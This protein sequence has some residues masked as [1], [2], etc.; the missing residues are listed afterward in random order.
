MGDIVPIA[1]GVRSNRSRY[2]HEG[3]ARLINCY[4]EVI[5]EEGKT[6]TPVYA[7]DGLKSW[8][9]TSAA[10]VRAMLALPTTLYAVV[11]RSIVAYDTTGNETVIG[12]IIGDGL[13]TMARNR[14]ASTQ[15]GICA[16]GIFKIAVGNAVVSVTDADLPPANS[17]THFDGYF[18]LTI[19]DGRF[20]VTAL[21]DGTSIDGL[22][23]AKAEANPDGLVR[24]AVRNRDLVLFGTKSTEFWSNTGGED[25][26]FTRTTSVDRGC[27]AP[28]SVADLDQTLAFVADDGTVRRLD[29]YNATRIST[30]DLER[31][32]DKDPN[33]EDI[34]GFAWQ[35][36][37]HSFYCISGTD[38]TRT[39]DA[40]TGLWHERESYR[41]GRWR[42][43]AYALF[44]G[45]HLFG[46]YQAA[47]IYEGDPDTKSEAGSPI[48]MTIQTP[49]VHAY[50]YK[51]RFNRV[52]AD[53]IPGVGLNTTDPHNDDPKLILDY[54]EDGGHNWSSERHLT[55]GMIGQSKVRAYARR[56]GLSKEDGRILRLRMS[57]DVV[58]GITGLSIDVDKVAA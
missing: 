52:F 49:Q 38:W 56:L 19:D 42:C 16:D 4:V 41:L 2:G 20:F 32:I 30:H 18:V 8:A 26:P 46:D 48:V 50:P 45:K 5:G 7:I 14:A 11:G 54:S 10:N 21:N 37:G 35:R 15:V 39:Y 40:T 27:L 25:F 31:L 34:T 43:S 3:D 12:G 9:T 23:F 51:L 6:P 44:N 28:G 55:V 47:A 53:V 13:V 58:K 36:N 33:K 24:G 57:A 22:D 29:G 17:V 1:L